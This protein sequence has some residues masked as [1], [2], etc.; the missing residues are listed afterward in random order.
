MIPS[1]TQEDKER[2]KAN[3]EAW[4]EIEDRK[5]QLKNETKTVVDDT[6]FILDVK[7]PIITKLFKQ[8]KKKH[9]DG[10]DETDDI[11][12]IIDLVFED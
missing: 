9:E 12:A 6:S 7:K 3:F 5:E 1:I 2:V 8:L 10:Q 4:L 11:A